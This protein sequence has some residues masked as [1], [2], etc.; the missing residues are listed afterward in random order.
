MKLDQALTDRESELAT[1]VVR[2]TAEVE[3]LTRE[4]DD[5]RVLAQDLI[6]G[7]C[8]L[9][10]ADPRY[11]H[12]CEA[13]DGKVHRENVAHERDAAL[14]TLATLRAEHARYMCADT[15][16]ETFLDECAALLAAEPAATGAKVIAEAEERGADWGI[17]AVAAVVDPILGFHQVR[18]GTLIP[19]LPVVA[20]E[21]CR[22][23][24][25][26]GDK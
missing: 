18:S 10:D 12:G 9:H 17:K 11:D 8:R 3:R 6:A 5:A 21:V 2:L 14:V 13:C 20:A 4:R 22:A 1:E 16:A 25:E 19:G 15:A 26:R 23:A 24:R 7:V